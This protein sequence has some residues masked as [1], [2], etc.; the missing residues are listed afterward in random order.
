LRAV[1]ERSGFRV[2]FLRRFNPFSILLG[3]IL[4][5]NVS[6]SKSLNTTWLRTYDAL[7]PVLRRLDV[8]T[9][10]LGLTLIACGEKR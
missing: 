10:G 3:W 2:V 6:R 1:L 8:I 4:E 5:N 7:V 9:R